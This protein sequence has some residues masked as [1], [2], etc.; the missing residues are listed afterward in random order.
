MPTRYRDV[1]GATS[2]GQLTVTKHLRLE[3]LMVFPRPEWESFSAKISALPMS[4]LWIK[5]IFLS[6]AMT[7]ELDSTGRILISP[8][9][10]EASGITRETTLRGMGNYFELWDKPTYEAHEMREMK[11]MQDKMPDALED[12]SF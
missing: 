7:V 2:N 6:N 11:L 3:C 12:I 5:R 10:R 1:L 4:S 8:E 9:L